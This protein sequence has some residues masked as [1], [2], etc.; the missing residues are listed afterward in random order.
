LQVKKKYEIYD[1]NKDQK[2]LYA[3]ELLNFKEKEA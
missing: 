2:F 3:R 1:I